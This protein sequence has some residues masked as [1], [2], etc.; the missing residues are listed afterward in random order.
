MGSVK[1]LQFQCV[2]ENQ[3]KSGYIHNLL[4][5]LFQLPIATYPVR[6]FINIS[7][8][9][10]ACPR[11]ECDEDFELRVS[12]NGPDLSSFTKDDI[13]PDHCI[14]NSDMNMNG[15]KHF[16]IDP[17]QSVDGFFL[18]L[19]SRFKG[20]CVNVTR[21]LVYQHECPGH[22]RQAIGLV[23]RPATQAPIA[24][25]VPVTPENSNHTAA[26]VPNLLRCTSDGVWLN[27]Q[28]HCA[29]NKG[30]KLTVEG[31]N[32]EGKHIKCICH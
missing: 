28:T 15:T 7:Y 8:S 16:H 19:R 5:R 10:V 26:S 6:I 21:V 31:E 9:F 20:G 12:Y 30:Y 27:D 29:C 17:D 23:R 32:C 18:A 14:R 24:G 2:Q 11:D 4:I 3:E 13:M 1:V 25:T 22:D